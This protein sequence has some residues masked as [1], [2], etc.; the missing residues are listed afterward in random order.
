MR[1]LTMEQKIWKGLGVFWYSVRP[2]LFY[3]CFPALLMSFGMLLF[4]GRKAEE[5]LAGSRN[6][7]HAL[8][9][10]L[11]LFILHRRSKKRGSSILKD[12][13]IDR[14]NL[15]WKR[16]FLLFG[17]GFGGSVVFSA[18]LTVFPFPSGW[19]EAYHRS[20]GQ[21]LLGTDQMVA[22]L[23]AVVLAPAAE[24]IIFRGY[25]LGRLLTWFNSRH[26][27]LIS[28]LVFALCHVSLLWMAYAFFLGLMLGWISVREDNTL[29]SIALHMGFN[30]S[31]L[32]IRLVNENA[33]MKA[34]WFGS[35]VRIAL[36]GVLFG[37][38]AWWAFRAYL[39]EEVG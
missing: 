28:S 7:Y 39:R 16:A 33:G 35:H 9:I 30:A 6:F 22:M 26:A 20:S 12:S 8:G 11:T 15:A 1:E 21:V 10:V 29:Y 19:M 5:V 34:V 18:L 24:E 37:L 23:S 17:A 31:I 13:V 36:L 38:L 14:E 3:L 4:G 2:L 32:P 27:V 25:M